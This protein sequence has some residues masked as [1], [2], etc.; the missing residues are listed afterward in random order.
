MPTPPVPSGF[1]FSHGGVVSTQLV[2]QSP[3]SA[4]KVMRRREEVAILFS[5]DM[6]P[7]L[8]QLLV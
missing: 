5:M 1:A 2:N 3:A 7:L 4:G 6:P 8:L